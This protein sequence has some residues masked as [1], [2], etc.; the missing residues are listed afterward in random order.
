MGGAIKGDG[1][2]TGEE[3]EGDRHPFHPT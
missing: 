2:G 1:K 3:K